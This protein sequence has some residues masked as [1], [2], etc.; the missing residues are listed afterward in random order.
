MTRRDGI[1][2][3]PINLVVAVITCLEGRYVQKC[4]LFVLNPPE[5]SV[6]AT[7]QKGTLKRGRYSWVWAY[8]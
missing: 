3:L 4:R 1:C 2:Y 5:K 8:D 7:T 6:H